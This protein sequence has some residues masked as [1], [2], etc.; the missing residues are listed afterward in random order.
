[1]KTISPLFSKE[2]ILEDREHR[3]LPY[4]DRIAFIYEYENTKKTKNYFSFAP[5]RK[6]IIDTLQLILNS[7][8]SVLITH[9]VSFGIR[10]ITLPHL[11]NLFYQYLSL[12]KYLYDRVLSYDKNE[13]MESYNSSIGDDCYKKSV[14]MYKDFTNIIDEYA[15]K[16]TKIKMPLNPVQ[17]YSNKNEYEYKIINNIIKELN[18]KLKNYI[19]SAILHGSYATEDFIRDYSDL[20]III[21]LKSD[22]FK[23]LYTLKKIS[24]QIRNLSYE[25]YRVDPLQH[26]GFGIF[27]DADLGYYPEFFCP[28]ILF[29][30][31]KNMLYDTDNITVYKRDD[32]IDR[33]RMLL[34]DVRRLQYR[35]QYSKY[36]TSGYR[37]KQHLSNMML[38]PTYFLQAKGVHMY[39]KYTFFKVKNEYSNFNWKCIDMA[40]KYR[41]N[42]KV[43]NILRFYPHE[44]R[45]SNIDLMDAS[46]I[47]LGR[48]IASNS[49][50]MPPKSLIKQHVHLSF[51]LAD[52]LRWE[53]LDNI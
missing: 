20:D 27:T 34:I 40:S 46:L 25:V 26:H 42:W 12:R 50:K 29:E 32:E 51:E 53:I 19:H 3:Y 7:Y 37:W 41:K 1:M 15:T 52:G 17:N 35:V 2:V 30:Y 38:L 13:L 39:K 18:G 21:I 43:K 49:V 6:Y 4:I 9:G 10:Q 44:L 31:G 48:T 24:N 45:R 11:D 14:W 28:L 33:I 47:R 23:D 16:K 5:D 36:P 8:I 22:C